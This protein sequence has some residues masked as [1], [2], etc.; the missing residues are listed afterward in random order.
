M[1]WAT[2]S[3]E[4]KQREVARMWRIRKT[5]TKMA[6]DRGYLVGQKELD[7]TLDEF[8]ALTVSND[9]FE[10]CHILPPASLLPPLLPPAHTHTHSPVVI[11]S[12]FN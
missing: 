2:L 9:S 12:D 10:Y 6:Y 8:S 11:G 7:I 4:Q 1:E 3:K 5:V